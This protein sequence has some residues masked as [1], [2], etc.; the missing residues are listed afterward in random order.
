MNYFSS[1]P[2]VKEADVG[3]KEKADLFIA[4]KQNDSPTLVSGREIITRRVEFDGGDNI[5]YT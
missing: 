4:L 5:G 2:A 3:R 1:L